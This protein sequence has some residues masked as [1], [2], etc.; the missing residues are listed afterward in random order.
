MST[1]HT[2][3]YVRFTRQ[4]N[5]D[6]IALLSTDVA[7]RQAYALLQDALW[8]EETDKSASFPA[9][10]AVLESGTPSSLFDAYKYC[11]D[12]ADG[13]Q[14]AY[15]GAVAYRFQIPAEALTG[16][17]AEVVSVAVPLYVDRWLVD[18]VRIA[19]YV[20]DEE[21]PPASWATVRDGDAKL[22][23][24]LPM[25]YTEDD[26]P[27]RVVVEKNGTMTVTMHADLDS[28][29]YLYVMVTLE[30]YESVRGFWIEGAGLLIGNENI[31]TFDRSVTADPPVSTGDFAYQLFTRPHINKDGEER[32]YQYGNSA[33]TAIDMPSV[34]DTDLL[35]LTAYTRST[36]RSPPAVLYKSTKSSISVNMRKTDASGVWRYVPVT[37]SSVTGT[38]AVSQDFGLV[39]FGDYL[40]TDDAFRTINNTMNEGQGSQLQAVWSATSS[41]LGGSTNSGYYTYDLPFAT[42]IYDTISTWPNKPT[43]RATVSESRYVVRYDN[44]NYVIAFTD[45]RGGTGL[46]VTTDGGANWAE[47]LY[48]AD[49]TFN[50]G[51]VCYF[52]SASKIAVAEIGG[53]VRVSVNGGVDWSIVK[54][55]TNNVEVW[56]P[57]GIGSFFSPADDTIVI[58]YFSS[59][60]VFITSNAGTTWQT[61]RENVLGGQ[62][63]DLSDGTLAVIDSDQHVAITSDAGTTWITEPLPFDFGLP[64]IG[65]HIPGGVFVFSKD[66]DKV[67][68]YV[69]DDVSSQRDEVNVHQSLLLFAG[70]IIGEPSKQSV[71]LDSAFPAIPIWM[72]IDLRVYAYAGEIGSSD[73]ADVA[74]GTSAAQWYAGQD[75]GNYKHLA[76]IRAYEGLDS[77]PISASKLGVGYHTIIISAHLS[78]IIAKPD[79]LVNGTWYGPDWSPAL[80][81]L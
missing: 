10:A 61:L 39:F 2:L 30:D 45:A 33:Y 28:K 79:P 46:M 67:G 8:K 52:G 50:V 81:K 27:K 42:M 20:S 18:G 80:I 54:E 13:K 47:R 36:L 59:E 64:R 25:T 9:R 63:A 72:S 12:Y 57:N 56:H 75:V 51:H 34:T 7:A 38:V 53:A 62:C 40:W 48:F 68:V 44:D 65:S 16:T 41:S 24:Q 23:A 70:G 77:I 43:S 66:G 55:G 37:G 17:V 32:L 11:G 21:T 73:A 4:V 14:K 49:S 69:S 1:T 26:P 19:A 6:P 31:V 60:T 29:K 5:T 71:L 3:D 22:L 35:W 76:S 58:G 74:Y 78:N 15:A